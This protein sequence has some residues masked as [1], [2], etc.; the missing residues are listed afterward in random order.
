MSWWSWMIFG[1]LL[2]AA[3]LFAVDAQFYLVFLGA[4]AV[5]VGLTML[6]GVE[7]SQSLQWILFALLS[8]AFMFT[9]RRKLY[10]MLRGQA[11]DVDTTGAG[12]TIRIAEELAPGQTCRTEFRGTTWNAENVADV[13]IHAGDAARIVTV[14]GLTL[15]VRP[16]DHH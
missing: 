14:V 3:E 6:I 13:A 1:V 9:V 2:F 15:H 4:G 12:E 10:D 7:L 8:I 11:A 5:A 16:A